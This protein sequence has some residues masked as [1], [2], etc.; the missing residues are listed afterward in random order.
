MIKRIVCGILF[1]FGA[2]LLQSTVLSRLAL[3]VRVVPDISLIFLVFIAYMNGVMTGQLT[4]FVSG[5]LMD[6]IS[7]APLGFHA[8]VRTLTGAL[9][10]FLKGTFFVGFFLLPMSLCAGATLFKALVYYLLHLILEGAVPFYN[11]IGLEFLIELGMNTLLAPFLF[12][13]LKLF[14]SLL[15]EQ[16]RNA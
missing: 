6:F 16:R 15:M 3:Y 5:F 7:A 11:V 4:G 14:G 9:A 13:F 8:F 1:I 10:G 2:A 12:F